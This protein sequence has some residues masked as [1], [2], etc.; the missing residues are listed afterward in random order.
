[1]QAA[2]RSGL[3]AFATRENKF[4]HPFISCRESAFCSSG[5]GE[6]SFSR[7]QQLD[8][9]DFLSG[10]ADTSN[11]SLPT[12]IMSTRMMC[13]LQKVPSS[14]PYKH[15]RKIPVEVC[16]ITTKRVDALENLELLC[17]SSTSHL[18]IIS[19]RLHGITRP[20]TS[21]CKSRL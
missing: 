2:T 4:A 20:F 19:T 13:L 14:K 10:H 16:P 15:R 12:T 5:Q 6:N 8:P 9:R 11:S 1:M 17:T 3:L 18:S 7:S 21:T